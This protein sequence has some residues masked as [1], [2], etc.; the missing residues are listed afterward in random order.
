M[1]VAAAARCSAWRGA[2][3]RCS[4]GSLAG[5]PALRRK[6]LFLGLTTLG[7]A[8]IIDRFVFNAAAVPGRPGGLVG[9]VARTC[10]GST[11]A[12]TRAFYFYELAVVVLVLLVAHNL[13]SGRLGRVLAAMR[14]SETAA[15]S[16]GIRHA[17][18][19]AV[20][21]R[22]VVGHGRHRRRAAHAGERELGRRSR[23]T[24]CF[25]LFWFTAVVVCGVSS[26]RR[27][28]P[29]RR[30]STSLI[31]RWLDTDIQSAIGVFGLG[32]VFLG[33]LPG[34][35]VAQ[36]PRSA[37]CCRARSRSSTAWPSR[38]RP[39]PSRPPVPTA[40]AERVLAERGRHVSGPR[41]TAVLGA[42]G[43]HRPLRRAAWP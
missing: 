15:Q 28:D 24:R 11:S 13:R 37:A 40:F 7:L 41:P 5:Y 38:R 23:S 19:E 6:G 20:R 3:R 35:V 26:M 4:P 39:R 36:R 16:I 10:S 18:G 25:G 1:P 42:R 31:P 8:L 9:T 2:S 43:D 22:R 17:P 30:R 34:G 32:A 29:G 14:D 21:V 27:R 33:R 12:A